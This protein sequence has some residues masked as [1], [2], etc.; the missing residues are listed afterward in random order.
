[1]NQAYMVREMFESHFPSV[2]AI[3][4]VPGGPSIACSTARWGPLALPPQDQLLNL[5]VNLA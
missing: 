4:T 3:E 5:F 1:M 2:A